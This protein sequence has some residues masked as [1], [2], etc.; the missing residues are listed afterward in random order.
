MELLSTTEWF[1]LAVCVFGLTYGHFAMKNLRKKDI[2]P[3]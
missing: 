2:F 3:K 1:M